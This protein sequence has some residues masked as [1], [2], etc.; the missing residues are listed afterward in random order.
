MIHIKYTEE[1]EWAMARLEE[2][3]SYTN[4][5]SSDQVEIEALM[6]AIMNYDGK[7]IQAISKIA[8]ML[9]ELK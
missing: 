2:L 4:R 6:I 5:S 7:T 9:K 3:T 8:A 1:R